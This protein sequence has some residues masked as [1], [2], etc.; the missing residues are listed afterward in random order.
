MSD[1]IYL[2]EVD[3]TNDYLHRHI[4]EYPDGT[5]VMADIQTKGRGRRGHD[6]Y[7]DAYKMLP[8]SMLFIDPLEPETL[9]ARAGLAVC[10]ALVEIVGK[11][12]E[13]RIKWPN[14]IIAA[15]RKVCGILC[16]SGALRSGR[17][18]ICGIGINIAQDRDYFEREDLPHAG[19]LEMLT[20]RGFD[21]KEIFIK[22]AEKMRER[23][24]MPFSECYDEFKRRLINLGRRVRI[25]TDDGERSAEAVDVAQNGYLIC[26]DESG[27]FEVGSGEVTV[28]GEDGYI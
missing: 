6:W 21:K 18:V 10:D 25:I 7:A 14:D 12:F 1:Y 11:G 5:A 23:V 27:R 2:E 16:E 8:M 13:V 19:S 28:R 26:S 24:R 9:T 22:V 15:E 3:S 4:R 20:G 17:Y